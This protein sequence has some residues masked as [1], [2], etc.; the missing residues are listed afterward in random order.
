VS[1]SI[2]PRLDTVFLP[3][4]DFAGSVDW[5]MHVLGL[6]V[7][8]RDDAHGYA[9]LQVGEM[10]ITLVRTENFCAGDTIPFNFYTDDIIAA[11]DALIERG[12]RVGE[13]FDFGRLQTFD[14]WD[15]DGNRLAVCAFPENYASSGSCSA[16]SRPLSRSHSTS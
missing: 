6:E 11:K 15:H 5:Y 7:R 1:D 3:V 12:A 13:T 10:S 8:W 4:H 16:S 14:F 2:F 9:A